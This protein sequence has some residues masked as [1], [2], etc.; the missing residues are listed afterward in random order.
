MQAAS[1]DF[2][3]GTG[4]FDLDLTLQPGS[5]LGIIG[6]SGSGKTTTVRLLAG[7]YRPTAGEVKV[8]GTAPHA[9]LDADKRRIGYMPQHFLLYPHLNVEENLHFMGGMYGLHRAERK[10][11]IDLLLE[12]FDLEEARKRLGKHLSGGMKRRLMLAGTLLH[13]P[14]LIFADEPTAGIDPI[15]RAR[16]WDY[17]RELRAEQRSLVITTQYVGEAAY[18]DLVAVMRRG[19]IIFLDTPRGLRRQAMGGDVIHMQVEE[20]VFEPL[21]ELLAD[22][23]QVRQVR[24]VDDEENGMYVLVADAER[25]APGLVAVLRDS[26]GVT[27]TLIE[28]YTPS[29]DE[30]FVRL[31]EQVE[32]GEC[33]PGSYR[34]IPFS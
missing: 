26:L 23:P 24:K 14:R 32:E 6:P 30:V 11:R 20:A 31:I 12:F 27:P 25:E 9:F 7:V 4:V 16:I 15:L 1:L 18:C 33:A 8:L 17:F 28:Q 19:R 10:S 21:L 22:L 34:P 3:S 29:F 13:E 2:G 5:I